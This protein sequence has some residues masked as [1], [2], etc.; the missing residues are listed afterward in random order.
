MKNPPA[1]AVASSP[2][3]RTHL[4]TIDPGPPKLQPLTPPPK[5]SSP[6]ILSAPP[7]TAASVVVPAYSVTAKLNPQPP[8]QLG[9][10]QRVERRSLKA[11]NNN[12]RQP[13]TS[14]QRGNIR[15]RS[16]SNSRLLLWLR[17]AVCAVQVAACKGFSHDKNTASGDIHI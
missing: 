8:P 10:R 17:F 12:L 2:A 5:T 9:D 11:A 7:S 1:S 14:H 15:K 3:S 4:H 6:H 16:E 13:T